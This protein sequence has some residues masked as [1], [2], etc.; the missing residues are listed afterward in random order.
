MASKLKERILAYIED[1]PQTTAIDIAE[2]FECCPT[3]A[4]KLARMAGKKLA[5]HGLGRYNKTRPKKDTALLCETMVKGLRDTPKTEKLNANDL[6]ERFGCSPIFAYKI[7]R[8]LGFS[9]SVAKYTVQERKARDAERRRIYDEK[10]PERQKE[11]NW[12]RSWYW[13]HAGDISTHRK[14]LRMGMA[15]NK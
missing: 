12:M 1:N 8:E 15:D 9:I 10:H 2:Q 11:R 3:Y 5:L 7:A 13:Q 4:Y 14:K 6:A